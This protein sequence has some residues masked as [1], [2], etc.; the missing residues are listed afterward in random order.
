MLTTNS[1][2]SE[3]LVA[4]ATLTSPKLGDR[5]LKSGDEII[6]VATP[7]PTTVNP[8]LRYGLVPIFVEIDIETFD[9]D[10]SQIESAM[11]DNYPLEP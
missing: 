5:A 10:A 3:N 6:T 1:G 2:T 4:V 11:S 9:I 7:F 8:T